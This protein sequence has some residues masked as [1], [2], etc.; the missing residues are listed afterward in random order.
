MG[1]ME[2][3]AATLLVLLLLTTPLVVAQDNGFERDLRTLRIGENDTLEASV[4]NPLNS[5]DLL[6][7]VL[8]GDALSSGIVTLDLPDTENV[9]CDETEFRCQV[10]VGS[11]TTTN[12]SIGMQAT[13]IGQETLTASVNSSLSQLSARDEIEV[14][15]E[16]HFAPVTVSAPGITAAL[17]G[18]IG[19]LGALVAGY[20]SR[21]EFK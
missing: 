7:V 13:A 17:L 1:R 11:N 15:V 16:P 14:R 10:E 3:R 8:D 19:L 5:P 4:S 21:K 6:T 12:F 18:L 20:R 2:R 9:T